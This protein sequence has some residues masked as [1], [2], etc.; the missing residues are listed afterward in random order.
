MNRNLTRVLAGGGAAAAQTNYN[1]GGVLPEVPS[2]SW[3]L[4]GGIL[5]GLLVLLF[6]PILIGI[7]SRG[8]GSR[9]IGGGGK[10]G[11]VKLTGGSTTQ[12]SLLPQ[13]EA[14]SR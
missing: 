14:A 7:G 10:K 13:P 12:A 9:R 5:V 4:F 11:R 1:P 3:L 8:L 2:Q 6:V